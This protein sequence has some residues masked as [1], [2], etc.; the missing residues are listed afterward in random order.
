ML[1][2]KPAL[3]FVMPPVYVTAAVFSVPPMMNDVPVGLVIAILPDATAKLN[4]PPDPFRISMPASPPFNVVV[5]L[6]LY[7]AS[8]LSNCKPV[9]IVAFNVPVLNVTVPVACPP[10]TLTSGWT[11]ELIVMLPL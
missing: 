6:K 3:F 2:I 1:T 11:C 9:P 10:E 8:A 7:A 5:P 4:V